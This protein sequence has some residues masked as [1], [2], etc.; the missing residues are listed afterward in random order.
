M[1]FEEKLQSWFVDHLLC[2]EIGRVAESLDIPIYAV[3]GVVRDVCLDRLPMDEIDFLCLGQDSGVKLAK[4]L[5]AQF[6]FGKVVLYE[7]FGTAAVTIRAGDFGLSEDLRLEFVGARKESYSRNSRKPKVEEGTLRED[8]DRRDFTINA[9]AVN[10]SPAN[11]GEL[12]DFH[13]GLAD[14]DAKLLKTPL[15]PDTTFDD[16]PLRMIRG[17]RFASQVGFEISDDALAAMARQTERIE[18]VSKER[19]TEELRKIIMSRSPERGFRILFE[20]GLLQHILPE[21]AALAG[22]ETV[23]GHRHKDNFY[24]TLQ[25]LS[26]TVDFHTDLDGPFREWILWAAL[27]HDIGKPS[28]KRFYPKQGWTFHGHE[29]ISARM[30]PNLFRRMKLPLDDRMD[31]VQK[32][33]RLHHRPVS[34]V[35]DAVTD[36]A[37]RRLLFDA[38]EDIDD[39]MTLVRADITSKNPARVRKYLSRFDQVDEKL[40]QVEEKDELRKFQP[41]VNGAEIMTNLDLKPGIAVGII[42]RSIREAIL[43]GEIDNEHDAAF[44][45]MMQI[46]DDC[47]YRADIFEKYVRELPAKEKRIIPGIKRYIFNHSLPENQDRAFD[48]LE[49]EKRKLLMDKTNIDLD[50]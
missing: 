6:K 43:D 13:S 35:G 40:T 27:L 19:I 17:A 2:K 46:R 36:S 49:L 14:L 42:K 50:E 15:D 10:I 34:L 45:Y 29:E 16:D 26:N 11:Y 21:L 7:N 24:H 20:T 8:I 1:S 5:S 30:V 32:L 41:P 38:G 28:S 9:M 31:Y 12:I 3:G 25:V 18:I 47:L 39:L 48:V 4:A 37:V 44:A 33:V 22:V 23:N